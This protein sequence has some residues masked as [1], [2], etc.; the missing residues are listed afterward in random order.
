MLHHA[1]TSLQ[2]PAHQRVHGAARL[3]YAV[4]TQGRTRLADLYQR[5]PCRVLFPDIDAGESAQAV[6]LT[7]SGGLTGGDRLCIEVEAGAGTQLTVTTQAAEKLYRAQPG[8]ADTRIDVN[9]RVG[10]AAWTE[11]LAQETILF[12]RSR[13]RRLLV[14]DIEP[15]GRLLAVESVVF[16]RTAM[17]ERYD[18]GSLHDAWRI[19]VGGCLVWADALHLQGDLAALRRESFGF[20]AARACATVLYA[21]AD[22]AQQLDALRE[23]LEPDADL[24]AATAFDGLL[25]LRLLSEDAA[26]MRRVLM[27]LTARLRQLA[28]GLPARMPQVW[29]C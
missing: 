23:A 8:E 5:A 11:W 24:G 25:I 28:T 18:S 9:L 6:L 19:R 29:N 27:R 13:L 14:A 22:A 26:R 15:Q 20:G 12:D 7:T 21:G 1:Q 4:D 3:V 16:G 2:R 17:G 10:A